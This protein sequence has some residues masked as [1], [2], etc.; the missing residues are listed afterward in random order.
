MYTA[1]K[2]KQVER[3]MCLFFPEREKRGKTGREVFLSGCL[4]RKISGIT[5]RGCPGN[6]LSG[7]GM[8][9]NY[10]KISLRLPPSAGIRQ[11]L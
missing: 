9:L 11:F 7:L 3:K 6:L 1:G 4:K 5:C 2:R 8:M 10:K